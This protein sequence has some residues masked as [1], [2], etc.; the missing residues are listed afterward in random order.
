MENIVIRKAILEDVSYIQNLN[1]ELFKLEKENYDTTLVLNWAL[2]EDGK[3][4]FEDLIKNQYCFKNAIELIRIP[5]NQVSEIT[6]QDVIPK[7]SRFLITQTNE[8]EYYNT[9]YKETL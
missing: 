9:Y 7:T 6:I 1:N 5:F 2:T 4:Y 8:H 3:E